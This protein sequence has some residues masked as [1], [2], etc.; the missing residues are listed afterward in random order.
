MPVD[1]KDRSALAR[2]SLD[3]L[4]VG[5][6]FGQKFFFPWI[7]ESATNDNLPESPW[8]YTDDTE[9]A[10]AVIQNLEAHGHIDQDSL[11]KTFAK[12]FVDEPNRGYG[13]GAQELLWKIA[14]GEHWSKASRE[15][16]NG[17]G[18]YGNGAA[19][20]AA[21][22]GAW[23]HDDIDATIENAKRSAEVTHSHLE[24]I[25][26]AIAVALSAAWVVRWTAGGKKDSPPEMLSWIADRLPESQVASSVRQ[27]ATRPLDGWVFDIA[28][29][30]G[31]G[32]LVTAQDTVAFSLWAAAA[33][34]NDYCESLWTIAR[35]G[36]DVD[37]SLIHI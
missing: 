34:L 19:M 22:I 30:F 24:G 3:G 5:D 16:F 23:F 14:D 1:V 35:V 11:A 9:M 13:A 25:A 18:S 20:R 6:G 28:R 4:S 21:P 29:E 15:L 2:L 17:S 37:L 32:D 26:G 27:V 36:G 7:V 10:M 31:C 33:N 8:H 12:R